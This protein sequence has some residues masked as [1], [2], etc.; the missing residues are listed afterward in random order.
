[1]ENN[2][3]QVGGVGVSVFPIRWRAPLD[4]KPAVDYCSPLRRSVRGLA[5]FSQSSIAYVKRAKVEV[6]TREWWR[7][8]KPARL[9]DPAA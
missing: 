9:F 4:I 8:N 3:R 1:M 7:R 5:D 2:P 6:R